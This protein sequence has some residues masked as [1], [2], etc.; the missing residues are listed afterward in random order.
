MKFEEF[1]SKLREANYGIVAMNEYTLDD[2][3]NIYV[4]VKERGPSLCQCINQTGSNYEKVFNEIIA[5]IQKVEAV[6]N[7]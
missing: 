1:V 7:G 6:L 4:V 5:I 3:F 2:I